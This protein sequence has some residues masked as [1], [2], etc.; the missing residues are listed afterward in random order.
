MNEHQSKYD[1]LEEEFENLFEGDS[2]V[3]DIYWMYAP[4]GDLSNKDEDI[5]I[6]FH[7][8]YEEKVEILI[9]EHL[10]RKNIPHKLYYGT[11]HTIDVR[12]IIK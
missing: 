8:P 4:E 3:K 10:N 9:A 2:N 1:F 7:G 6:E 11:G 5:I 12:L